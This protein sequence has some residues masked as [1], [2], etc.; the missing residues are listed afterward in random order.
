MFLESRERIL[1]QIEEIIAAAEDRSDILRG[2]VAF[3]GAG[4]QLLIKNRASYNLVCNLEHPGTNPFVVEKIM[5]GPNVTF[6]QHN[7]LHAKVVIGS[8]G[9]VIGSANFSERALGIQMGEVAGWIEAAVLVRPENAAHAQTAMWFERLWHAARSISQED[10]DRAKSN[11]LA[12]GRDPLGTTPELVRYDPSVVPELEG[13][14]LCEEDVFEAEPLDKTL[15]KKTRMASVELLELY[16]QTC[17]E[18]IRQNWAAKV[19]AHSANLLWV[20]SGREIGTNIEGIP[21]F[22]TPDMVIERSRKLGTFEMLHIFVQSLANNPQAKP[23]I[24][25]WAQYYRTLDLGSIELYR[26]ATNPE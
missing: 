18:E 19:A 12:R 25:F 7:D 17:Q 13:P 10:I 15:R 8:A 1:A 24:R 23:A 3:W 21:A 20:L 4:S 2:A 6:Q 9:A 11:W 5:A 22:K 26:L 16:Q 14:A